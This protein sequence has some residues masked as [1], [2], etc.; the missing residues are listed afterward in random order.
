MRFSSEDFQHEECGRCE[1]VLTWVEYM[2]DNAS[3]PNPDGKGRLHTA[4][5][6]VCNPPVYVDPKD[7]PVCREGGRRHP[8]AD[9]SDFCEFHGSEDAADVEGMNP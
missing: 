1:T 9:P 5:C 2:D 6:V 7:C 4:C 8:D 3:C